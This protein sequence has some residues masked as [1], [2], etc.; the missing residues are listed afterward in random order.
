MSGPKKTPCP[1]CGSSE[2]HEKVID[3]LIAQRDALGERV[4][5]LRRDVDFLR[6]EIALLKDGE[7]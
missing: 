2:D 7:K 4:A 6:A 5:E 3:I 1:L